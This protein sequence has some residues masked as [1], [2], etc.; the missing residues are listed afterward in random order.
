MTARLRASR[1]SHLCRV[2]EQYDERCQAQVRR[3]G[4]SVVFTLLHWPASMRITLL[5]VSMMTVRPS[6][7]LAALPLLQVCAPL[8]R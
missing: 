5:C 3:V 4:V 8:Q 7:G 1:G 2:L 6:A